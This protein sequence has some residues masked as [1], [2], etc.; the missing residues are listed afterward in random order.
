MALAHIRMKQERSIA[1][2]WGASI[3]VDRRES[4]LNEAGD[5]VLAM[6]EGVITSDSIVAE[7]G[8]VLLAEKRGR[9]SD[10]EITLLNRLVWL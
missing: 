4:A 2:R 8:E 5:Y 7:I 6:K 10:D 1:R 3:F 9:R